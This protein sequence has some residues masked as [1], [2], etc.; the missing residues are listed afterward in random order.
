MWDN[1]RSAENEQI[2][3]DKSCANGVNGHF[4]LLRVG[5]ICD[6]FSVDPLHCGDA[7]EGYKLRGQATGLV[8]LYQRLDCGTDFLNA[9]DSVLGLEG[10]KVCNED[11]VVHKVDSRWTRGTQATDNLAISSA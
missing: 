11:F 4:V 3:W 8:G 1:V 7:I 6:V 9:G 2:V 5:G 10:G